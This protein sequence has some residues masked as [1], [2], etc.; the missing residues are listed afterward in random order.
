MQCT[1]WPWELWVQ[2]IPHYNYNM[3]SNSQDIFGLLEISRQ[4]RTDKLIKYIGDTWA[5][6]LAYRGTVYPGWICEYGIGA[7]RGKVSYETNQICLSIVVNKTRPVSK[8]AC[9]ACIFL[10]D[11]DQK[12]APC[13]DRLYSESEQ[14]NHIH[15]SKLCTELSTEREM[16]ISVYSKLN[17]N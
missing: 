14:T 2:H 1:V 9:V 5:I 17:E 12:N 4:S 13:K 10:F 7:T 11:G 8:N 16:I 3:L 15:F 6:S